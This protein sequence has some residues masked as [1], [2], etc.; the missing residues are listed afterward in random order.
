V[1]SVL[2]A[3]TDSG[4]TGFRS[5]TTPGTPT[6]GQ[7]VSRSSSPT[8]SFRASDPPPPALTD[9]MPEPVPPSAPDYRNVVPAPP[10]AQGSP[11]SPAE[12]PPHRTP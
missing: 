11:L 3:S 6:M 10:T 8:S 9:P 12:Y 2:P 5:S 7:P 4:F 1:P